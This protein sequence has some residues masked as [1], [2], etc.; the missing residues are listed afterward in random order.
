[1]TSIWKASHWMLERYCY[2]VIPL[3]CVKFVVDWQITTDVFHN[4][5]RALKFVRRRSWYLVFEVCLILLPVSYIELALYITLYYCVFDT[6][7]TSEMLLHIQHGFHVH[8]IGNTGDKCKKAGGHYNP[9]NKDHGAPGDAE[10]YELHHSF[11]KDNLRQYFGLF[12]VVAGVLLPIILL[13]ML[14]DAPVAYC[15]PLALFMFLRLLFFSV[16]L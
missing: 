10:R 5:C 16:Y 7:F 13:L 4:P 6:A 1:M 15:V 3:S 2:H 14:H 8:A 11:S 12:P 9:L